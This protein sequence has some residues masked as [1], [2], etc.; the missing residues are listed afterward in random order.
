MARGSD[1]MHAGNKT[2]F[3]A[4]IVYLCVYVCVLCVYEYVCVCA[5]TKSKASSQHVGG[6]PFHW[7][8]L[9][10]VSDTAPDSEKPSEQP[11]VHIEPATDVRLAQSDVPLVGAG[12]GK[13]TIS[14]TESETG[15]CKNKQ[16]YFSKS[17][18]KEVEEK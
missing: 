12:I 11:N 1:C 3:G 7:P 13:H 5:H 16:R 10:H 15:G 18:K 8:L 9:W 14:A 2:V 17:K 4:G 6:A